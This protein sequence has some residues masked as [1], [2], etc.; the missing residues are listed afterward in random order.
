MHHQHRHMNPP[1]DLPMQENP[2]LPQRN[3]LQPRGTQREH[4]H[5]VQQV[6]AQHPRLPTRHMHLLI[7]LLRRPARL[8]LV[9]LAQVLLGL[10]RWLLRLRHCR[11]RRTQRLLRLH[12]QQRLQPSVRWTQLQAQHFQEKPSHLP[13][14]LPLLLATLLRRLPKRHLLKGQQRHQPYVLSVLA[15]L[16][17]RL[18]GRLRH[19]LA[20]LL[21]SVPPGHLPLHPPEQ[22]MHLVPVLRATPRCVRQTVQRPKLLVQQN[23]LQRRVEQIIQPHNLRRSPRLPRV[24]LQRN[25]PV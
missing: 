4:Q 10:H 7:R 16:L 15:C 21:P 3:L 6:S 5:I 20:I 19:H 23:R 11:L 22:P 25:L 8:H 17:Q 18:P 2:M 13:S 9:Q 1:S 14:S 24:L 12:D